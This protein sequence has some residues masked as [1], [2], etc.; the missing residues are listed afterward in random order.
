MNTDF[1]NFCNSQN[2]TKNLTSN[3]DAEKVYVFLSQKKQVGAMLNETGKGRPALGGVVKELEQ[4]Y[5]NLSGFPFNNTNKK[6]TGKMIR[7]ILEPYGYEPVEEK[8]LS[9]G[10]GAAVF[11]NAHT[12]KYSV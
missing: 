12:Y 8:A 3:T 4:K 2:E 1:I 5:G 9:S 10:T 11:K 6:I 7:H